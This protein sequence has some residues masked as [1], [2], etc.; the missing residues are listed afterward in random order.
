[1]ALNFVPTV[2]KAEMAAIDTNEAIKPYSTAVAP[3]SS[4]QK[5]PIIFNMTMQP[6]HALTH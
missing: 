4:A 6:L 2:V 3:R 5:L 1:V